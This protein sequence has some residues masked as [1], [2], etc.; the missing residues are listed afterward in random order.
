MSG[1]SAIGM[2]GAS[3]SEAAVR[4]HQERLRDLNIRQ[5]QE[6]LL[7]AIMGEEAA[8]DSSSL[9]YFVDQLALHDVSAAQKAMRQDLERE[10]GL[11][12]QGTEVFGALGAALIQF[13]RSGV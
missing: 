5:L 10:A 12:L 7:R 4:R 9:A 8:G 13:N 11:S 1:I 2:A 3:L 6:R